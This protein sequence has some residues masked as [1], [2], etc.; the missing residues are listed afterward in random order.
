VH[1]DCRSLSHDSAGKQ[2]LFRPTWGHAVS[3]AAVQFFHDV[4]VDID[5]VSNVHT[6]SVFRAEEDRVGRVLV[7]PGPL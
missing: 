1:H 7:G 3:T 6:A 4:H 2:F 5:D